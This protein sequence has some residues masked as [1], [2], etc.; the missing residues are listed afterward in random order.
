M[1][2]SGPDGSVEEFENGSSVSLQGFSVVFVSFNVLS[3]TS[4]SFHVG[5][6]VGGE[7][8]GESVG[9]GVGGESV[10]VQHG[11]NNKRTSS[12]A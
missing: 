6:G 3:G 2:P 10:P 5:D 1:F 7:S 4:V 11:R 9:D 8:V 12:A